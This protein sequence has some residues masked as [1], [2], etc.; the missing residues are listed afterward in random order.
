MKVLVAC[1]ES[2]AVTIAF[3]N[4]GHEAYSC[5]LQDCSGG[6]PEWHIKDDAIKVSY[7]GEWDLMIGHPPCTHI[8]NAGGSHFAKKRA[9][10]SQREAILFFHK[11]LMAPIEKIAL[12]NPVGIL[13]GD[14][15]KIHYPDLL[16]ELSLSGLPRKPDQIIQPFYFGDNKRKATCLWLKNL[17]LLIWKRQSDLFYESQFVEPEGPIKTII[18]KGKYR[19]GTLRKLYWY[20]KIS[21]NDRGKKK[22]KTFPGIAEAMAKQW[23][24]PNGFVKAECEGAI[25]KPACR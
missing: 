4:L 16:D 6:H 17:P 1:E 23:S 9:D 21:S 10:G 8:A 3:R 22:S 14:Y 20:D 15:I 24:N 11:L 18:R 13:N 7:S 2:Q 5:D 12:E 19:T 25:L